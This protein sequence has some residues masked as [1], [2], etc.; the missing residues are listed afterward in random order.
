MKV[1]GFNFTKLH[2]DKKPEF[3]LKSNKEIKVDFTD[4]KEDKLDLIK[5]DTIYSISFNYSV[6]YTD[7]VSKKPASL[8]EIIIE[9]KVTISVDKE[10]NKTF[11]KNS[12]K[13]EF[14]I[15]FKEGLFNFLLQKCTPKALDLEDELGL[16]MH[17]QLPS[18]KLQQPVKQ[19]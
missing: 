8:A 7:A 1:I 14:D 3:N 16:P 2:A 17:L 4:V 6:N 15:K 13:K 12:K 5:A 11:S 10:E 9:G 19:E 18:I